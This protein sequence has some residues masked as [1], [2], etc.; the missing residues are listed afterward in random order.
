[1]KKI[2]AKAL[3][4]GFFASTAL[5][6]SA[7]YFNSA[8]L[9]VCESQI[10]STL[11]LGSENSQ[12]FVLQQILANEGFLSA[13]PNGY[14]GRQTKNAVQSFQMNN[15]ISATGVVGYQT[16]EALNER[17]CNGNMSSSY[18]GSNYTFN[19]Y[20]YTSGITSVGQNDPYITVINPPVQVPVVYA[21]PQSI[22]YT[23]SH[24]P[25]LPTQ[26]PVIQMGSSYNSSQI[27]STQ[28]IY[29]PT[30]G[31]T[32]GITPT[33]GSVT[34]TSPVANAA[35]N[36]GDTVFVNWG[37]NNLAT[38]N[39]TI[40]LESNIS[41][42]S[43]IVGVTSGNSYS[44]VL[45]KEVLDSVCSGVCDNNQKGS[46]RVVVTTPTTDIAGITSTLRAAIAPITVR[47]PLS[48][49]PVS[50]SGSKSPVNSAE[51]FRLYVNV[52]TNTYSYN[53]ADVYGTYQVRLK[54]ICPVAVSASIAGVQC[55]QEFTVPA[56]VINSQ[57]EIPAI[58]TNSTWYKQDVTFVVTV[59][60]LANQVIGQ[61]S[62]VVTVNAVPFSF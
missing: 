29:S 23:S 30:I 1:M 36:E 61:A 35:Y 21:T 44:F 3:F 6:V 52:P 31:Y 9:S 5:T 47:R 19:P 11:Q 56:T 42:Q 38:Y 51:V 53:N 57:Q 25:A 40:L 54:A 22:N 17:A 60:N 43:K 62:T 58:I 8:P 24:S 49:A 32:Y 2:I 59:V 33:S 13:T 48:N 37:T 20:N 55:G 28:I 18:V 45:T 10:T 16:R 4:I 26:A 27:A 7:G 12:V 46:F 34:V 15:G 50:I 41:G 14:F 39:F